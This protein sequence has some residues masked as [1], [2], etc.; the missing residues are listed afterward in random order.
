MG[1][2]E[3]IVIACAGLLIGMSKGGFGPVLAALATPMLSQVMPVSQAVATALPL[4]LL[5]DVFAL[6][7]YWRH[8]DSRLIRLLVPA[9]VIGVFAGAYLL[10]ALP[11]DLLRPLLGA[12]TLLM[13]VYKLVRTRLAVGQYESH[14]WHGY[15]AGAASGFGSAVAN[16]GG[17]P[18]TAYLLLQQVSPMVFMGTTTLFFITINLIKL[19]SLWLAGLLDDVPLVTVLLM[20]PV[21]WLG[22][23]AGRRFVKWVD[24]R[25]F[26]ILML[27]L[28]VLVSVML[29]L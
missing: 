10:T 12:L 3:I 28:L 5:G 2:D 13:V 6:R 16:A 19:P 21:V 4:L 29:F 18:F 24:P 1:I 14:N 25:S 27:V 22:I 7:A 11:D 8:W 23:W 20:L 9:A 17:P 26:D 15:L